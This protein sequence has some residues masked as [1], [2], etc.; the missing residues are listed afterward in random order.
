MSMSDNKKENKKEQSYVSV[1]KGGKGSSTIT[2][3]NNLNK[4]KSPFKKESKQAQKEVYGVGGL[5]SYPYA[6]ANFLL[7]Y[8][9][10]PVFAGCV[11]QIARDVAGLGWKL[12]LKEGEKENEAERKKI[13]E[14]LDRPNPDD[15]LRTVLKELI[16]DWGVIGW[17]GLEVLRDAKHEVTEIF[18]VP[19]HTLKIHKGKKKFFQK[20]GMKEAW[21]KA[22]GTEDNISAKDGK[23]GTYNLETRASELIFYKNYYPRS[24]FYGAPE[25]LSA[26]GSVIALTQIRD[27]NM[28]FFEN[29]GVPAWM[30][31]LKG[32]WDDDAVKT[33]R[34]FLDNEI[35]GTKN[36]KKTMVFKVEEGDSVDS[37]KLSESVQEASFKAY[38][39][40]L[41]DDILM[42]Y[43]MPGYRLGLNI[44]G[45]LG[46]SN[47]REST[48]IYKNGVVE[49]LQEDI[50]DMVNHKLIEE[51]L[52]CKSYKFKLNDLDIR[53]VDAEVKRYVR[54][55]N[56]GAVNSNQVIN[57]LDLGKPYPE[58]DKYYI[59]STLVEVGEEAIEK[60]QDKFMQAVEELGKDV[61]KLINEK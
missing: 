28:S 23:K 59:G 39:Q 17:W 52:N 48:E 33:I 31:V 4:G 24:D 55:F 18:H 27:Y 19:A 22:F 57:F 51:G 26:L 36:A 37:E 15:S 38:I 16:I 1:G 3:L 21:F 7:L 20:R 40:L 44:V 13:Q 46:G 60:R 5:V 35:K 50:E 47:I 61:K 9:A 6:P 41:I 11:K 34:N 43:S 25:I 2:L 29:Y 8:E 32:N 42:S 45:K 56:M 49:P 58:G 54:L 10:N 30:I 53:D 12:V 14:F